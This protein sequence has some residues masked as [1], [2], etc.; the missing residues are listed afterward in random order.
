MAALIDCGPVLLDLDD[1]GIATVRL[2]R[3]EAA[4]AMDV[5][6]L[7]ALH[8]A[9]LRCH[10]RSGVRAVILTGSGKHFCSGGD[11][12]DFLLRHYWLRR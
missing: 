2:N 9:L 3:P 10:S 5:G 1:H 6:L 4:N 8:T 7:R 11:V 12:N